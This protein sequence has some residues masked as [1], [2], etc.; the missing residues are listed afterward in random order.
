MSG[1]DRTP[2][3]TN[4][5]TPSPYVASASTDSGAGTEAYKAFDNA[6]SQWVASATTGYLQL[7]FGSALWAVDEYR[8]EPQS[9]TRAPKDW[10]LKASNTGAY[11]GEEVTLDTQTG[12]T[13]WSTGVEKTYTFSNT[14]K[15]RYYRITVT[16]NNG[17]GSNLEIDELNFY[18]PDDM[19][20]GFFFVSS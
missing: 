13:T 12:V 8:I 11:A 18:A 3:M 20:G 1:T 15:Y 19:V 4:N 14:T 10:T 17:D 5:T 9:T 6:D 2:T 16:A 7:D